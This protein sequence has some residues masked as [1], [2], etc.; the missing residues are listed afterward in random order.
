[1][2]DRHLSSFLWPS[3]WPSFRPWLAVGCCAMVLAC[4]ASPPAADGGDSAVFPS[5]TAADEAARGDPEAEVRAV[6]FNGTPGSYRVEVTV[7]SPDTGCDQYADWW[8][9]ITA[10]G[11]LLHRRILLHSHVDEQPFSRTGGP[12]AIEPDNDIIVRVHMNASGYSPQAMQGTV[13]NGFSAVTLPSDFA[14]D[15]AEADPLPE[16]CAF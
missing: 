4:A 11:E 12:V 8:E 9:V 14:A 10:D 15:L 5:S 16:S 3:L 6:A 7:A 2:G 1:M 13:A